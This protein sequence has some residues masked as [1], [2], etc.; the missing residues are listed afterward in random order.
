M[1]SSL[2]I[3]LVHI[4]KQLNYIWQQLQMCIAAMLM[5]YQRKLYQTFITICELITVI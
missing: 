2:K 4:K 1:D 3:S 5:L